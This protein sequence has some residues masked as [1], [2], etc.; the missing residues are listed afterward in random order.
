MKKPKK[1]KTKAEFAKIIVVISYIFCTIWVTLSYVLSFFG[2]ES[3]ENLSVSIVTVLLS[4][5]VS[6]FATK[7]L[8]KNSRNKYGIDADGIPYSIKENSEKIN[9]VTIEGE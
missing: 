9:D 2:R 6:Y 4:A 1:K 7:F 3:V 5:Q 8:E